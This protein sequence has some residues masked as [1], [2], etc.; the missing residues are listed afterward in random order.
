MKTIL[1]VLVIAAITSCEIKVTTTVKDDKDSAESVVN[2]L[3]TIERNIGKSWDSV[4]MKVNEGV[5]TLKVKL[6]KGVDTLNAR[7]DKTFDKEDP[8]NKNK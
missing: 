7:L 8:K 3:D 6:N 1:I 4:K 2:I 5:D